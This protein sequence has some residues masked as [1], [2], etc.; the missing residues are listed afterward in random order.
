MATATFL[1]TNDEIERFM[2]EALA[3]ARG[4]RAGRTADWGSS[5]SRSRDRLTW[6]GSPS[7]VPK[8]TRSCRVRCS[9][10]WWRIPV[11]GI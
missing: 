8:P 7:G 3:D 11:D 9:I 6:A 5:R 4:R 1:W 10:I 2:R